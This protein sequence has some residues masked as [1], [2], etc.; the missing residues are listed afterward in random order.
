[1]CLSEL[2]VC[3]PYPAEPGSDVRGFL[4]EA[5][6]LE[7]FIAAA[8]EVY[9]MQKYAKKFKH[10]LWYVDALLFYLYTGARR[11][12][13]RRVC[14]GD[15]V[16]PNDLTRGY[17]RIRDT[18][19]KKDRIVPMIPPALEL[20]KRL[21]ANHRLSDDPHEHVLKNHNGANPISARYMSR[22]FNQVRELARTPAIGLH[23]LR[24]TFAMLLVERGVALSA[25]KEILGHDDITTT[26]VYANMLPGD[27]LENVARAFEK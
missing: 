3:S 24:H 16:F 2:D 26:Q 11:A 18:K 6:Q 4:E 13:A 9:R 8:P 25:I 19:K 10:P 17:I 20:L 27:V 15:V 5:E 14:W 1:M 7:R 22:K 23:G 21:E 12:E